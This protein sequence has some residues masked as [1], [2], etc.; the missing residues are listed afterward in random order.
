MFLVKEGIM[1][2]SKNTDDFFW[3]SINTIHINMSCLKL[4][5]TV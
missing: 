1:L 3:V 5:Q 2:N 4:L